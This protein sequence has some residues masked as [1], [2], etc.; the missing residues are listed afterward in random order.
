MFISVGYR[1][2]DDQ[3]TTRQTVILVDHQPIPQ[4]HSASQWTQPAAST[5]AVVRTGVWLSEAVSVRVC[6][7]VCHCVCGAVT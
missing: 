6:V 7:S 3:T 4:H 5:L 2:E 1:R